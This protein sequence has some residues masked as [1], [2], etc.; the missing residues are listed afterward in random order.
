MFLSTLIPETCYE[1]LSAKSYNKEE[2]DEENEE[3]KILLAAPEM[4]NLAEWEHLLV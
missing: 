2:D 4:V 1:C 3:E